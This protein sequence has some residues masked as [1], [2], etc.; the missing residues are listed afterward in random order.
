MVE[1]PPNQ[2]LLQSWAP[3]SALPKKKHRAAPKNDRVPFSCCEPKKKVV[4]PCSFGICGWHREEDDKSWLNVQQVYSTYVFSTF[5]ATFLRI[6]QNG[7]TETVS[8]ISQR[9]FARTHG[10]WVN[11]S[12]TYCGNV[13]ETSH[14]ASRVCRDKFL[15]HIMLSSAL[16]LESDPLKAYTR[17]K[18]ECPACG[19]K[20]LSKWINKN[21]SMNVQKTYGAQLL[22]WHWLFKATWINHQRLKVVVVLTGRFLH[23]KQIRCWQSFSTPRGQKGNWLLADIKMNEWT[24][25]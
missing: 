24:N 6:F 5:S 3:Y 9:I 12:F 10:F 20:N 1:Q 2:N 16:S 22:H 23:R 18:A 15:S 25:K 11:L 13:L 21:H 7:K 8:I 4:L 19:R 17:G 14:I